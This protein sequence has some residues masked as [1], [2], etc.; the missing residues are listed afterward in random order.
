MDT[1][2]C[3]RIELT[4]GINALPIEILVKILS[5]LPLKIVINICSEVCPEWE[6]CVEMNFLEPHLKR[7]AKLDPILEK[8]M[9]ENKVDS[10]VTYKEMII[11][12]GRKQIP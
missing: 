6:N 4:R 5:Y 11:C 10:Y 3:A 7:I 1:N 8:T 2:Y 9:G 12:Q